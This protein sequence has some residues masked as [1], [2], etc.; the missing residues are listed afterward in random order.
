VRITAAA[1]N[2]VDYSKIVNVAA[3][4]SNTGLSTF[5]INGVDVSNMAYGSSYV[6][7]AKG[8][9]VVRVLAKASDASASV[10]ITGK[11]LTTMVDGLYTVTV[12]V[13]AVDGT[14][15]QYS[16]WVKVSQ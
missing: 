6:T 2:Y 14:S 13:T 3:L 7:V 8:T 15:K 10:T 4:R 1:G 11:T 12:T 5:T 16:E 9:K